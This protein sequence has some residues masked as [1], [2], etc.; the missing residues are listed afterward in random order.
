[1]QRTFVSA[2]SSLNN[3]QDV[4]KSPLKVVVVT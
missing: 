3:S 4:K 1:M 2:I